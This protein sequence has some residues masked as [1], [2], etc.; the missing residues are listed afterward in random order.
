MNADIKSKRTVWLWGCAAWVLA[1]GAIGLWRAI[2]LWQERTLLAELE[3]SLSPGWLAVLIGAFSIC[4]AGLVASAL[5]LW[6]RQDWARTSARAFIPL[7]AIV[8]QVYN[9]GFV[10][11]GLMLERRWVAVLSSVAA[12]LVGITALTWKRTRTWMGL[13]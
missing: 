6:F 13:G 5:G 1:L 3:S 7:H 12:V 9:W 4:G 2:V 10:R 8:F 11:S